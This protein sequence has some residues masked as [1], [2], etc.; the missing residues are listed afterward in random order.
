[1]SLGG[2]RKIPRFL[3]EKG[4]KNYSMKTLLNKGTTLSDAY[5]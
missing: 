1:V 3:F 4:D 5:T 2:V